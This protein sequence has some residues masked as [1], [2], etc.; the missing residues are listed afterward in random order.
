M[1]TSIFQDEFSVTKFTPWERRFQFKS[2][3]KQNTLANAFNRAKT[4]TQ[5]QKPLKKFENSME[6][7]Y[8][9][10]DIFIP[11][12]GILTEKVKKKT[13]TNQNS[14]SVSRQRAAD[15]QN[16][17]LSQP[18]PK[19]L[20]LHRFNTSI[21]PGKNVF[22]SGFG[23][24]DLNPD[25]HQID[26]F[27]ENDFGVDKTH[28][29]GKNLTQSQSI[30]RSENA[31]VSLSGSNRSRSKTSP[32][33]GRGISIRNKGQSRFGREDSI[34]K[35]KISL[36]S[37]SNSKNFQNEDK[38]T[39]NKNNLSNLGKKIKIQNRI[40]FRKKFKMNFNIGKKLNNSGVTKKGLK[41][42]FKLNK[43]KPL[44][45]INIPTKK[46]LEPNL[47]NHHFISKKPKNLLK[48]S[49]CPD[50]ASQKTKNIFQISSKDFGE[51]SANF[52]AHRSS[53]NR[54]ST[55]NCSEISFKIL[56]FEESPKIEK[57]GKAS[58]N[59]TSVSNSNQKKEKFV[60]ASYNFIDSSPAR[61]RATK[62]RSLRS[63]LKSLYCGRKLK[64]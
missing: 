58:S 48:I 31:S 34:R 13:K 16:P 54:Q 4:T 8:S 33:R 24:I 32:G 40:N 20:L 5:K 27:L 52:N 37:Q 50:N 36:L 25:D 29:I 61:P 3:N 30:S 55:F 35:Q 28:A 59:I 7:L 2:K 45:P 63:K 49:L 21:I 26:I 10:E 11:K 18:K 62:K 53:S 1:L 43:S 60:F 17:P 51:S 23:A 64:R 14:P 9:E 42:S 56:K 19:P 46:N 12:N 44:K 41:F 6:K 57:N 47:Y 38:K 22:C 39:K 15:L